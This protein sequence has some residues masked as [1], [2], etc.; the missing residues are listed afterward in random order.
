MHL[1]AD[2]IVVTVVLTLIV[3]AGLVLNYEL[4]TRDKD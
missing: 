1:V 2:V 4:N 3:L